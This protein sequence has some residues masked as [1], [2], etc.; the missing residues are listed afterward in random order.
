MP[1]F[2]KDEKG[3]INVIDP[4]QGG[5]VVSYNPAAQV[6]TPISSDTMTIS[7]P[8][9]P[10]V[11]Q[12]E[13]QDYQKLI[14]QIDSL[15]SQPTQQEQS[16][17]A[18]Q[19]RVQELRNRLAPEPSFRAQQ[20]QAQDVAGKQQF[21]TDL[22][23]QMKAIQAEA[24]SIPLALETAAQGTGMTTNILGAQ[25]QGALRQNAIRALSVGAQLQAAQGNLSTALDMVDRA[26]KA[27]FDPIR[28]QLDAE[29]AN[30]DMILKDP[31]ASR[32]EKRRAEQL[33]M[34]KETQKARLAEQEK[35]KQD[36]YDI[37]L[38]ATSLGADQLAIKAIQSA[39]TPA[40]ALQIAASLGFA[41]T[42][43]LDKK[44]QAAFEQNLSLAKFNEDKRQFGLQYALSQQRLVEEQKQ[45]EFERAQANI[46][47][48]AGNVSETTGKP[49][50][51]G[52][53][54]SLGYADRLT[55][56]NKIITQIG[57][58]FTGVLSYAGQIMPNILKGAERQK[59]E[60]AQRNF[61][62]AVLRK[63]SGAVISEQEFAN[64]RQQYFPQ[65]GDSAEV[66]AQKSDNRNT[67]IEGMFRSGGKTVST[68]TVKVRA[69]NG[70]TGSIPADRLE[71]AIEQGYT[72]I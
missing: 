15:Y 2:R 5:A 61:I 54:I 58:N 24:Q 41:D 6:S 47:T 31:S 29:I 56:A 10:V 60:Q 45:K 21:V 9:T 72:P 22:T 28:A 33:A 35:S 12:P 44:N 32:E 18:A 50:T 71:A 14:G 53:R 57:A 19:S 3:N 39:E 8:M 40:E 37:T 1:P 48:K 51:E 36:I 4:S 13:Y 17:T 34:V 16:F 42:S 43:A 68:Q 30:I 11:A 52:E 20:Q 65:P 59:Y 70:Q 27:E 23:N 55:E 64:A 49:L 69:P 25:Q 67:V 62:N 46:Q 66:V 38:K 63:E 7:A 26:V